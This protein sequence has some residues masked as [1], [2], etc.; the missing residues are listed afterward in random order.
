M[1]LVLS[2]AAFVML[3]LAMSASGA[4]APRNPNTD[5]DLLPGETS[6]RQPRNGLQIRVIYGGESKA[7]TPWVAQP[8]ILPLQLPPA[9]DP[10]WQQQ[11]VISWPLPAFSLAHTL[12]QQN[13]PDFHICQIDL[14]SMHATSMPNRLGPL[15]LPAGWNTQKAQ[16]QPIHPPG[17]DPKRPWMQ[18][19]PQLPEIYCFRL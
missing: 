12:C 4:G 1:Q 8:K 18:A 15:L 2:L 3:L 5:A 10:S 14:N 11:L 13:R 9:F 7:P 19:S 17:Q 6:V 16:P